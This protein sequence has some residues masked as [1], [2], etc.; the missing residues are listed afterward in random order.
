MAVQFTAAS[1]ELLVVATSP[2]AAVPMTMACWFNSDSQTTEQG[3]M[4]SGDASSATEY[5]WLVLDGQAND[6]VNILTRTGTTAAA[7]STGAYTAGT[8]H[9]AGAVVAGNASRIAYI[10]GVAGTENTTS[11]PAVTLDRTGI[12]ALT[13]STG[14]AAAFFDGRIAEATWWNVALTPAEMAILAAGYSS[15]FV[16]PGSRVLHDR[17]I[18]LDS[19]NNSHDIIG[20][21]TMVG[22]NTPTTAN[23]PRII[24]PSGLY[25]PAFLTA[26]SGIAV[27]RR[28]MEGY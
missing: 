1:S 8:W 27:L 6:K 18:R 3:L 17:L 25:V 11:K 15:D 2:L 9:H 21:L 24:R 4:F 20:G 16:R 28:R 19:G 14:G 13:R 7:A 22:V 26:V 23:H 10:D 12:G 5:Q